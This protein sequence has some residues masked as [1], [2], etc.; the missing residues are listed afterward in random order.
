V[1][2]ISTLVPT[3][4]MSLAS[5]WVDAT[6]IVLVWHFARHFASKSVVMKLVAEPT[7]TSLFMLMHFK[8]DAIAGNSFE[9]YIGMEPCDDLHRQDSLENFVFTLS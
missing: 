5:S 4:C 6:I 3:S 2:R 9:P 7:E 8:L 1:Y